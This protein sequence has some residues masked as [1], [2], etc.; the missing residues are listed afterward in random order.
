LAFTVNVP[1]FGLARY[2][3]RRSESNSRHSISAVTLYNSLPSHYGKGFVRLRC[4][5]SIYWVA[6]SF[7]SLSSGTSC[8]VGGMAQSLERWSGAGG[9]S[10]TCA[11]FMIDSW[12]H[13]W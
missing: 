5:V 8:L 6:F 9:L 11:W 12:P 13:C 4:Y 3:L 1:A 7:L 2:S 10:V